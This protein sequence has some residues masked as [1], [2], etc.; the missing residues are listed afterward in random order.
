MIGAFTLERAIRFVFGNTFI[1]AGDDG[2][3]VPP[4]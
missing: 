4:G 2:P 1:A 3:H